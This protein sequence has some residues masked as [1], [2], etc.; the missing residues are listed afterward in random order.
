MTCVIFCGGEISDYE[1]IR[2]WP[3]FGN[4]SGRQIEEA[5]FVISADSGARHCR[6]LGIVPDIM[7]GD[8]DSVSQN[9][10]EALIDAG[11]KAL[12]YPAEKD[13]TDSELAVEIAINK[14][15]YRVLLFGATGTRLDHSISNIFLLKKLTDAN[16]DGIIVNE[17]SYVR[18]IKDEIR[19]DRVEDAYV[20]LLP[21]AGNALG[22]STQG[23]YYP[24]DDATLEV[25]SSWGVSNRF[26]EDTACIKLKQGYLLVITHRSEKNFRL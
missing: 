14:G 26:T 13:M 21:F 22:V 12:Q 16:I 2:M 5:G 23:L 7:V 25:G 6:T 10:Y 11:S 19:L 20:T 15:F 18:L 24:L 17:T 4:T 9:D 3:M 1:H 8:F